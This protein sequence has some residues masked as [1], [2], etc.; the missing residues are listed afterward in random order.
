MNPN[1][2]TRRLVFNDEGFEENA[3]K[4]GGCC[5]WKI[6]FYDEKLSITKVYWEQK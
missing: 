1:N 3:N 6:E 4:G 2:S 5:G